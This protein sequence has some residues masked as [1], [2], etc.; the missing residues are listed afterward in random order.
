MAGSD[1]IRTEAPDKRSGTKTAVKS[2][3]KKSPGEISGAFVVLTVTPQ[4]LVRIR[5]MKLS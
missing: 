3:N 5:I 1:R 4:V 2:P